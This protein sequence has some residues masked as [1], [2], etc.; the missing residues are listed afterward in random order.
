MDQLVDISVPVVPV[1]MNRSGSRPS[2]LSYFCLHVHNYTRPADKLL[3][4]VSKSSPSYV[5]PPVFASA[6]AKLHAHVTPRAV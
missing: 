2:R 1:P 6:C 5:R 3:G 4:M